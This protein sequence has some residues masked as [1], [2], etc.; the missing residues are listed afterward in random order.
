MPQWKLLV[1]SVR[2]LEIEEAL[3]KIDNKLKD[4]NPGTRRY[5]RGVG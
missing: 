2:L 1:G 5:R 3:M 4:L